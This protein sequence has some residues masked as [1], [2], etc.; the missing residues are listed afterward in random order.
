VIKIIIIII[1]LLNAPHGF[2]LGGVF[3]T[4]YTTERGQIKENEMGGAC[5]KHEEMRNA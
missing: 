5:R 2:G 1:I 3:T 4:T